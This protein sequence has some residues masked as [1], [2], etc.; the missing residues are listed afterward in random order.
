MAVSAATL[1]GRYEAVSDTY[2]QD[3]VTRGLKA[4]LVTVLSESL[5][6]N[7]TNFEFLKGVF[8]LARSQAALYGISW[9]ELVMSLCDVPGLGCL[10]RELQ[11][12]VCL[13]QHTDAGCKLMRL[14]MWCP[15]R[16][17]HKHA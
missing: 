2:F 3:D 11:H 13:E 9:P 16:D 12:G 15:E 10:V 5:S 4:S 7:R 14:Q 17:S 1:F 6:S 8:S